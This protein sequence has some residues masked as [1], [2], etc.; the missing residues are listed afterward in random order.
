M[1]DN[2]HGVTYTYAHITY[3]IIATVTT[4]TV[5]SESLRYI[6]YIHTVAIWQATHFCYDS[7]ARYI[8]ILLPVY[9]FYRYMRNREGKFCIS[10]EQAKK[11]SISPVATLV[12]KNNEAV[13]VSPQ[14][15]PVGEPKL[16]D[17]SIPTSKVTTV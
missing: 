14:L 13:T 6:A 3:I 5:F 4:I 12:Y 17:H 15:Q 11:A 9:T 1:E 2:L 10:D 8:I 7:V 16:Q